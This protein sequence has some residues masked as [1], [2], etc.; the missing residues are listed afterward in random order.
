MATQTPTILQ[1]ASGVAPRG[2]NVTLTFSLFPATLYTA[3][4]YYSTD[5]TTTTTGGTVTE[6]SGTGWSLQ[7]VTYMGS[8]TSYEL[9]LSTSLVASLAGGT[10]TIGIWLSA[11]DGTSGESAIASAGAVTIYDQPV[12]AI[13][14]PADGS[15][16]AVLPLVLTWT[17]T[18]AGNVG[19][20]SQTVIVQGEAGILSQLRLD[21]QARQVSWHASELPLVS[22][23]EYVIRLATTD[24]MGMPIADEVT[25]ATE[26]AAPT[27]PLLA[28]T[29]H[30]DTATIDVEV[31]ASVD[32]TTN[33]WRVIDG[34][35]HLL[36]TV[37]SGLGT[38]TD[39]LPPLGVGVTYEAQS[40]FDE[41]GTASAFASVTATVGGRSWAISASTDPADLLLLYG[42]PSASRSLDQ[43]G[44]AYHFADGGTH[45]GLPVWYG[46]TDRDESGS[47]SLDT[48]GP[49][50]TRQLWQLLNEHPVVWLRDP[51]GNRWR[52]H[53]T[54]SVKHGLGEVWE[55]YVKWDAMRFEEA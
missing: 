52:V 38:V 30:D 9:T 42:N 21:P 14:A 27:R 24:G 48:I 2:S 25:F 39:N 53:A 3:T 6:G 13:T 40:V 50:T 32:V 10:G 43:G 15:T 18:D 12:L 23:E 7:P 17:V 22:G 29:P 8:V 45:G 1:A 16:V 41:T 26:W 11:N 44:E 49:E 51:F 31:S 54:P 34:E 33:V 47:L 20:G 28:A 46:L 19:I 37:E 36:G 35:R 5:G 55:V 4:W